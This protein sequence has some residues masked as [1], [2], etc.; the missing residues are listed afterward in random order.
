MNM[1]ETT[2]NKLLQASLQLEKVLTHKGFIKHASLVRQITSQR[3]LK[4]LDDVE[5][6]G[7]VICTCGRWLRT[8]QEIEFYKNCCTCYNC[9][10][11]YVDYLEERMYETH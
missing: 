4:L 11:S 6:R 1:K 3:V 5:I 10:S 9:D 2:I 8:G 7:K